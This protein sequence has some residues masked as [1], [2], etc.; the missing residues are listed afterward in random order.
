M[1]AAPTKTAHI[2]SFAH[3]FGTAPSTLFR[4]SYP[5]FVCSH[6]TAYT[7][8]FALFLFLEV[9]CTLLY[10]RRSTHRLVNRL[11]WEVRGRV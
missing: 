8:F 4:A 6:G 5:L 2:A 1:Y 9:M 11:F 3:G 7:L 10:V